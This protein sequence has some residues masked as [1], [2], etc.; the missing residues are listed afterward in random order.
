M[1]LKGDY[2]QSHTH[3]HTQGDALV[4]VP[5]RCTKDGLVFTVTK[6]AAVRGGFSVVLCTEYTPDSNMSACLKCLTYK[7]SQMKGSQS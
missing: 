3:T 7:A 1:V 4:H 5:T 6:R 2:S